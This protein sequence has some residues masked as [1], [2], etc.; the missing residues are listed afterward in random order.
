MLFVGLLAV[1]TLQPWITG[2]EF[3][4]LDLLVVAAMRLVCFI[5][6]VAVVRQTLRSDG[7]EAAGTSL[8]S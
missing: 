1:L 6:F 2:K 4:P 8:A 3:A 5:P 7:K